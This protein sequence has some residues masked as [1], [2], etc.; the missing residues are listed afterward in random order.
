[1]GGPHNTAGGAAGAATSAFA[2]TFGRF[3]LSKINNDEAAKRQQKD[4]ERQLQMLGFQALISQNPGKLQDPAFVQ[5]FLKGMGTKAEP[6]QIQMLGQLGGVLQRGIDQKHAL[7]AQQQAQFHELLTGGQPAAT[8]TPTA[9]PAPPP[10]PPQ[11]SPVPMP[12]FTPGAQSPHKPLTGPAFD[13]VVDTPAIAPAAPALPDPAPVDPQ[14]ISHM[15]QLSRL[16]PGRNLTVRSPDGKQTL[17]LDRDEGLKQVAHSM[18]ANGTRPFDV[19]RTFQQEVGG[20]GLPDDVRAAAGIDGLTMLLE[21]QLKAA[22]QDPNAKIDL[23]GSLRTLQQ[24]GLFV[25]PK[26]QET[27]L[28]PIAQRVLAGNRR[29]LEAQRQAMLQMAEQFRIEGNPELAEQ[30]T[31]QIIANQESQ[32]LRQTADQMDGLGLTS[33]QQTALNDI[34]TPDEMRVSIAAS[35]A[36]QTSGAVL[37]SLLQMEREQ[38]K[39]KAE[40]TAATKR[41]GM[42]AEQAVNLERVVGPIQEVFGLSQELMALSNTQLAMNPTKLKEY[43]DLKDSLKTLIAKGV[44][45]QVGNLT[46]EEAND[47]VASLPTVV[48]L[49]TSSDL[50]KRKLDRFVRIFKGIG[51]PDLFGAGQPSADPRETTTPTQDRYLDQLGVK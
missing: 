44:F 20:T 25:T 31:D 38:I 36:G 41:A 33:A 39:L 45:G 37:N 28:Q 46:P 32:A 9:A 18:I 15:R 17:T 23:S 35:T 16:A 27:V 12:Q 29:R 2:D 40:E 5:N 7:A 21:P 47:A 13:E 49:F 14:T 8:A 43:S 10:A 42:E 1:M 22:A 19:F 3:L 26:E 51:G 48:D 34:P 30:L 6:S 24:Q 50:T 11:L 4:D